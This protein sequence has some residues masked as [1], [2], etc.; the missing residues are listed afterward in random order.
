MGFPK[1]F[2]VGLSWCGTCGTNTKRNKIGAC[3]R[4]VDRSMRAIAQNP[5]QAQTCNRCFGFKESSDGMFC[6]TCVKDL[7]KRSAI[8]LPQP[9]PAITWTEV[10]SQFKI[11][12]NVWVTSTIQTEP[13]NAALP[14]ALPPGF[15][16][17]QM[18]YADSQP[19]K[20]IQATAPR[21]VMTLADMLKAVEP[22][23]TKVAENVEI[24]EDREIRF[25]D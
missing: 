23:V 1:K 16:V 8:S 24:S 3:E 22:P 10:P 4:C 19:V 5:E 13:V 11:F 6:K 25:D 2:F 17:G 7:E 14:T 20:V 12:G 21:P 15:M 18:E 9:A